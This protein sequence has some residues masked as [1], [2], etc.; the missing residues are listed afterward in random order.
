MRKQKDELTTEM[1]NELLNGISPEGLK[2]AGCISVLQTLEQKSSYFHLH[3]REQILGW[4][5][6]TPEEVIEVN[7]EYNSLDPEWLFNYLYK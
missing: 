4:A 1:H 2:H 3:T 6:V 7:K 5:N